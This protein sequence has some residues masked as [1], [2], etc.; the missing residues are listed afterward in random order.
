MLYVSVLHWLIVLLGGDFKLSRDHVGL[1]SRVHEL[2]GVVLGFYLAES[3][4]M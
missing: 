4:F 3:R 2:D 1:V